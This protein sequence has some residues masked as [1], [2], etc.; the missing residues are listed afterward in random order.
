MPV[1]DLYN[2]PSTPED[3]HWWSFNH[4]AHHRAEVDQLNNANP[5]LNLPIFI[6]DPV[7]PNNPGVFL[8]QHQQMHNNTEVITGVSGYDLTTVDMRDPEQLAGWIFL[9]AD[10]HFQEAQI[11]GIW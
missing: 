5:G 7:D 6:L 8:Y 1:A 9:N 11:L 4:M 3:F 2:V 10:L